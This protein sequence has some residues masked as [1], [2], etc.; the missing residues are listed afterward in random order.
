MLFLKRRK[1]LKKL[2]DKVREIGL[3]EKDVDEALENLYYN[4]YGLCLDTIVTQLYELSIPINN[5]IY[6][7]I[8]H[9]ATI[10]KIDNTEYSFLKE[11]IK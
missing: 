6:D 4:E 1:T 9:A 2:I 5:D 3:P 10:M 7:S 8:A 11:L